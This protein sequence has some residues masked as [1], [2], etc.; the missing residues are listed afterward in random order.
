MMTNVETAYDAFKFKA[1]VRGDDSGYVLAIGMAGIIAA[2]GAI[3]VYAGYDNPQE[4]PSIDPL[5][6]LISTLMSFAPYAVIITLGVLVAGLLIRGS[7]LLSGP[8]YNRSQQ[9]MRARI[10]VQ[11]AI[12][13][14]IMGMTTVSNW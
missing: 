5:Q 3:A 2:F 9:L 1:R 10:I 4:L 11:F 8:R 7:I 12:I 6:A 14:V 13:C